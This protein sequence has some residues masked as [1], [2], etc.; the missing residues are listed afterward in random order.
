MLRSLHWTGLQRYNLLDWGIWAIFN[1]LFI[2]CIFSYL[3]NLLIFKIESI[4]QWR[5]LFTSLTNRSE[6]FYA[7]R[8]RI[9]SILVTRCLFIFLWVCFIQFLIFRFYDL[10]QIFDDFFIFGYGSLQML[11]IFLFF[12]KVQ[13]Y[14][15]QIDGLNIIE[16][17]ICLCIKILCIIIIGYILI[18]WHIL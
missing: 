16:Y 10:L 18:K 1:C 5:F 7:C 17:L 13:V 3:T 4:T 12:D 6:I 11:I 8:H 14:M 15:I 2:D 9:R